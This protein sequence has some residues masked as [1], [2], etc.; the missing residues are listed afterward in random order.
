M[1]K[2]N[3]PTNDEVSENGGNQK[4]QSYGLKV[5]ILTAAITAVI[6]LIGTVVTVYIQDIYRPSLWAKQTQTAEA[7]RQPWLTQTV[8]SLPTKPTPTLSTP[9]INMP[10]LTPSTDWN[11]ILR[12]S[13]N[14]ITCG[15]KV[16][17]EFI[18]MDPSDMQLSLANLSPEFTKQDGED[19]HTAI[20]TSLFYDIESFSQLNWIKIENQVN[21]NIFV[22]SDIP[23]NL[24]IIYVYGCGGGSIKTLSEVELINQN[25][26]SQ[27]R[28][29]LDSP[30]VDFFTL[31][32]G[33]FEVFQIPF[34]CKTPGI[35]SISVELF[36]E[37]IDQSF[38]PTVVPSTKVYCPYHYSYYSFGFYTNLN[39][40]GEVEWDGNEYKSV[41]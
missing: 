29:K 34:V 16:V 5:A 24:N 37:Y 9:I 40:E 33:E 32:P 26:L 22:N 13:P 18:L 30:G 41:P 10:T 38:S 28:I 3:K 23:D 12:V 31:Q 15:Y 19:W 2:L 36:A 4:K 35:Y 17:P 21:L 8:E 25:N 39:Y 6:G 20:S 7:I 14:Y 1:S 27:Y 11:T